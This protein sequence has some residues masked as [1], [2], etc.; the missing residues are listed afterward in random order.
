MWCSGGVPQAAV[1]PRRM[2]RHGSAETGRGSA[3][4]KGALQGLCSRL[5]GARCRRR[6]DGGGGDTE[7]TAVRRSMD[8][9]SGRREFAET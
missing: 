3:G 1:P 2:C 5:P 7:R 6:P 4:A 8:Q 9:R